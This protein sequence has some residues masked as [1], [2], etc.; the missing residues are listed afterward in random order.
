M[1]KDMSCL[2]VGNHRKSQSFFSAVIWLFARH[3]VQTGNRNDENKTKQKLISIS[4]VMS[5]SMASALF[6][7]FIMPQKGIWGII[8]FAGLLHWAVEG[9]F[10]FQKCSDVP[11]KSTVLTT[12]DFNLCGITTPSCTCASCNH[13]EET[14]QNTCNMA[15]IWEQLTN[16]WTFKYFSISLNCVLLLEIFK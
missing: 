6:V 3:V 13:L 1:T 5:N 11:I 7:R 15:K 9:T 8:E 16:V 14:I 10:Y 4:L 2:N 12:L